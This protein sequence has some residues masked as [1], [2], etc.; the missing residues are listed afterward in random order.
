MRQHKETGSEKKT[1]H[2]KIPMGEVS[3]KVCCVVWSGFQINSVH[4]KHIKPCCS[5]TVSVQSACFIAVR[6]LPFTLLTVVVC[7]RR[8]SRAKRFEDASTRLADITACA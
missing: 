1:Y 2:F 7:K 6:E 3:W 4:D 5:P 8:R